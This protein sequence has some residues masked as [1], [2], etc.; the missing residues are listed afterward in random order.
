MRNKTMTTNEYFEDLFNR[1]NLKIDDKERKLIEN[2]QTELRVALRGKLILKDDFLTGSYRRHTIIKPKKE[3]E[4]FDVD[5]FVAFDKKEYGEKELKE[6]RSLVAVALAEIKKENPKFGINSINDSQRRSVC[7]EY[8][9]NFFIDVVPSIEIEKDKLYKIFDKRTLAPVN[10]N[11]KLHAQLLTDA[12][13]LTGGKLVPIIKML[14]SWKRE[15][16]DYMKSFHLELLAVEILGGEKALSYSDGIVKF[17]SEAS[18][19]LKTACLKDPANSD[20]LIDAYLDTD[21]TR[22]QLLSLIDIEKKYAN[23]AIKF[24]HDGDSEFTLIEWRKIFGSD[25]EK[26]ENRI[27]PYISSGPIVINKSPARPWCNVQSSH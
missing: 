23:S 13:E 15:K 5:I 16:C 10:S 26:D 22:N 6:L 25:T 11:P 7:V 18:T 19:K 24:E 1:V 2:K 8:G 12:N 21:G 3:G 27:D 20:Y 17:F 9:N 4:M 14:K